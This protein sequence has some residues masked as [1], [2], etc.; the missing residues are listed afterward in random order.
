MKLIPILILLLI[1]SVMA[2]KSMVELETNPPKILSR[3][4]RFFAP[5][6]T[7]WTFTVKFTLAFPLEGLGTTLDANVPFPFKFD[8]IR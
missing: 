6:V 3:Q 5:Q 2:L 8:P 4:R 7:G 1:Q